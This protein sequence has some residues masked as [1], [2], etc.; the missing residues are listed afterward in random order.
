MDFRTQTRL[1]LLCFTATLF[2]QAAH[3]QPKAGDP[4]P[5]ALGRTTS[6][7]EVNL[8]D[9]RGKVVAVTF[10][11]S[12]CGPCQLELP[13]LEKLQRVVGTDK[14]RVV[15]VNIEDRQ[16]FRLATRD[17]ADW[18]IVLANDPLKVR[19]GSYGVNGIPHMIIVSRDGVIRKLFR[20][21]AEDQVPAV[22][23]AVVAALNE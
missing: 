8:A 16:Q 17:K 14:L 21:Y 12:W 20:G 18:Q 7:D 23:E 6:G 3:A 15:A 13:L 4:A 5:P 10:W 11:A 9:L 2:F 1:V 19:A 22:V